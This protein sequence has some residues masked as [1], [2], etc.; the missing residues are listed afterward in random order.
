VAP[1]AVRPPPKPTSKPIPAP[2][3]AALTFQ[4]DILP[5][6]QAKCIT[7]HG[8]KD[9]LKGGLDVRSVAALLRG[10][11]S[12]PGINR[13]VPEQS[14]IWEVVAADQMPPGKGKLTE[15]EKSKLHAWLQGG[16]K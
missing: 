15:A 9:K 14:L 6:L 16:A 12:G 8:T 1:E 13:R 4:K 3:T 2:S 5:I 10:G 11:D 7:C